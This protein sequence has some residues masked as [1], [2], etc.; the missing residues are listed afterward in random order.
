MSP[1]F[2]CHDES[3]NKTFTCSATVA[4]SEKYRHNF[5]IDT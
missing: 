2:I 5:A 1:K 3:S 4:C